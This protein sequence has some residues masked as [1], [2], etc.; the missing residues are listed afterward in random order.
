MQL[1]VLNISFNNIEELGDGMRTLVQLTE[2]DA[3]NNKISRISP[4][5][6]KLKRMKVCK[7]NNNELATVPP[8]VGECLMLE[9]LY[10]GYNQLEEI[11]AAI[12]SCQNLRKVCSATSWLAAGLACADLKRTT[13]T[14]KHADG[15]R[16]CETPSPP[17]AWRCS[18]ISLTFNQMKYLTPAVAELPILET[19]DLSGNAECRNVPKR[20][21]GDTEMVKWHCKETGRQEHLISQLEGTAEDLEQQIRQVEEEKLALEDQL[22]TAEKERL[23]LKRERANNYYA[24]K[25][26]TKG[27][28]TIS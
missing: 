2:L 11:P 12:K 4:E 13:T 27:L 20:S 5:L 18:Q 23:Q 25:S 7:L 19:I 10:L 17:F 3:S 9:E 28:C 22:A 8:Q 24:V 14:I 1:L 6:N 15:R 21:Q 16:L 26:K